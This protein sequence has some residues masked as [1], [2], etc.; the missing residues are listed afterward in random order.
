[1][2]FFD[3]PLTEL[4]RYQPD[5]PEPADFDAFWSE[6]LAEARQFPLNPTFVAVDYGFKTVQTYDV[7]F[8]GYGGQPIKGWLIIPTGTTAPLAGIIEFIGYGGGRA[9]P[10]NWLTWASAGYAFMVMDTRGQGSSWQAGDTPDMADGGNPAYPGFMT[11]GILNPR[12]YYYRRL[13]CDTARAI[14]AFQS[15]PLVDE[16]RIAVT[17]GSQGGGMTIAAS[18]LMPSVKIAM[19]DVPFLCHFRH[20]TQITDSAPYSEI[21]NY[22]KIHRNHTETV[23]NTLNYFDGVH[24]AKRIEARVLCSVALMDTIC[25]P[26]TVFAAYNAIR[27]EKEMMVY[28]YNGHEGGSSDH[29]IAKMKFVQSIWGV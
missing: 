19:P 25:P 1:M 3:L 2:P 26:S 21:V 22:L 18:A 16:N 10:L 4:Y 5:L 28:P 27:T 7:T 6:T 29:T 24:F 8:A 14:E 13:F 15:H 17:G 11:Q 12:H 23:F 9:T 20:A